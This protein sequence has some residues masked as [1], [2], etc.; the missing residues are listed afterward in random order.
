MMSSNSSS[1]REMNNQAIMNIKEKEEYIEN[2]E[3]PHCDETSKYERVAKIGQGTFGSV[4]NL[5]LYYL[6]FVTV[7]DCRNL[8]QLW[9]LSFREVFKAKDRSNPKKFVA[10]K[11]V[12]ME[13]EK[14]GVSVTHS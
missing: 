11:K 12:L 5:T 8:L 1:G 4:H 6:F 3:F 7:V 14:E 9:L 10:M 13:N 2:F